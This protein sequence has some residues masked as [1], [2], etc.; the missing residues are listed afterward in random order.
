[1][2]ITPNNK[3]TQT[4]ITLNNQ[5]IKEISQDSDEKY[6]K[7]LGFRMDN[8]LSWTHHSQHVINK[9]S[10]ANYLLA[11]IKNIFPKYIKKQIYLSLGQSHI[12]YG[13]PV[14]INKHASKIEQI[15]KKIIRNI[16]NTK[17]NAHTLELFGKCNILKIKD[18]YKMAAI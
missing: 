13:L 1:M 2:T 16:Y 5:T 10:T 7:F 12:E 17:Y 3:H 4:K 11:T 8:K 6:F 15:Q 14:W 18:L 9:L